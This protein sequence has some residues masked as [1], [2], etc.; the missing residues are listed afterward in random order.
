[1][2]LGWAALLID[3][4]SHVAECS[5]WNIASSVPVGTFSTMFPSEHIVTMFQ[6]EHSA[7]VFLSEHCA[8][9]SSWNIEHYFGTAGADYHFL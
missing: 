7:K 8:E 4:W 9:C 6:S 2:C 1:V 5:D 3:E